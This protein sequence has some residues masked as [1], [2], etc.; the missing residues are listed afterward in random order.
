M[1]GK[2]SFPQ[3]SYGFE[4]LPNDA[5]G[6]AGALDVDRKNLSIN[7]HREL[8]EAI[9]DLVEDSYYNARSLIAFLRFE[10]LAQSV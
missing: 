8:R 3:S 10:N 5:T 1:C 6:P 9:A 2:V 7:A 4:L